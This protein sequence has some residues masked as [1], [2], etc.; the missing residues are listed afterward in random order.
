MN[1]LLKKVS[2]LLL[3]VIISIGLVSCGNSNQKVVDN[4][5]ESTQ[6][7]NISYPVTITDSFGK[8]VTLEK[9]P[10]KIIS[11]APNIT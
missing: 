8:E 1:K 11:V 7:G 5:K 4:V 9:E 3:F 2:V 6:T 10:K